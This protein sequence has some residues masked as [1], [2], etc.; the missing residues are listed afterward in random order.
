M[1][2]GLHSFGAPAGASKK[3]KR[4]G[5]GE[6][7]G[8]GKTSGAGHKGQLARSGTGKPRP[9]FEGGQTPLY[10]RMPKRGFVH[11]P[12]RRLA[13]VNI[14]TIATF[15]GES[16]TVDLAAL[17]QRGLASRSADGLRVLGQGEAASKMT[18]RAEHFSAGAKAK[19]EAAGGQALSAA[20]A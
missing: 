2:R 4:R 18:I 19:I 13:A 14:G 17:I 10:R 9:G 15:F 6:S 1:N 3:K 12:K 20:A 8:L 5:R 11:I 16:A 7:S